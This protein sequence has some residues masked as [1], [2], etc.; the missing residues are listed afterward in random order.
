[1]SESEQQRSFGD[2][3]KRIWQEGKIRHAVVTGKS[4]H[5]YVDVPLTIVIVAGVLAPWLAALGV[6]LA[7]VMG[8]RLEVLRNE[9]AGLGL[10]PET[11]DL[12]EAMPPPDAD[13][14]TGPVV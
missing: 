14:G 6:V 11:P 8:C 5:R 2:Q 7:V 10:P 13:A 9:P 12:T 4:G 1:M 3:V